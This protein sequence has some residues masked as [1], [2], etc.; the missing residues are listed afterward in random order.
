MTFTSSRFISINKT[1]LNMKN[2]CCGRRS[3]T[4]DLMVMGHLRYQLRHSAMLKN[5][6]LTHRKLSAKIITKNLKLNQYLC[7]ILTATKVAIIFE[8]TK[9]FNKN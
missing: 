9:F 5:S 6:L 7:G 1:S 8:Y 4:S 3:R 2:T